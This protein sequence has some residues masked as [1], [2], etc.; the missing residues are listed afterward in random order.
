MALFSHGSD[1]HS[2]RMSFSQS[3]PEKSCW[4]LQA[5]AFTV[6]VQVPLFMQGSLSH[7]LISSSQNTPVYPGAHTH[8]IMSLLSCPRQVAPFLQGFES[9]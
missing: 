2:S 9:Q 3:V 4:Q 6:S 1:A 8:S 7:S 5:N